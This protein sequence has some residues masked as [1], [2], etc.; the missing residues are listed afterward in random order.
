MKP[1]VSYTALILATVFLGGGCFACID[2]IQ[3][4]TSIDDPLWRTAAGFLTSGAIFLGLALR[5]LRFRNRRTYQSI[6]TS[7]DGRK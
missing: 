6:K 2:L 5:A 7:A 4:G 3:R 1:F